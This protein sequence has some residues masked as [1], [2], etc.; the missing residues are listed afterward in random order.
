LARCMHDKSREM[1]PMFPNRS[2]LRLIAA[3]AFS[4]LLTA[5]VACNSP[6]I[7]SP[8]SPIPPPDPTFGPP[9]GET[10]SAGVS[11]VYWKV[12]SPPSQA[13]LDQWVY[14]ANLDLGAGVIVLAAS[15]GSYVTRTEGQED[16]R[17]EFTFGSPDGK[18]RCRLLRE[19]LANVPCQ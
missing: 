5:G 9:T 4:L 7:G 17:I 12:T 15:D 14:L 8:F 6:A 19:G 10:D 18:S 11:H 13:L 2:I 3:G 16:D 1:R